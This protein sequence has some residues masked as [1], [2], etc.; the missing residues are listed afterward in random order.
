MRASAPN[1][2]RTLKPP[3]R[4]AYPNEIILVDNENLADSVRIAQ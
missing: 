1:L 4:Q 3:E 2:S